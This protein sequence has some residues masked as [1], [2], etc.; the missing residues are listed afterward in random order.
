MVTQTSLLLLSPYGKPVVPKLRG[1]ITPKLVVTSVQSDVKVLLSSPSVFPSLKL[2]VGGTTLTAGFTVRHEVQ[3]SPTGL[4][5]VLV[6]TET[7]V[8]PPVLLLMWTSPPPRIS[9]WPVR[10]TIGLALVIVKRPPGKLVDG[11]LTVR[12]RGHT[13]ES[14]TGPVG[15]EP[16]VSIR[17]SSPT[18][19]TVVVCS[20]LEDVTTP[21]GY[22]GGE[23]QVTLTPSSSHKTPNE[24]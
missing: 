21:L 19:M 24:V 16:P 3:G 20:C 17:P 15:S 22:P 13:V 7:R 1:L 14:L 23:T 9:G 10:T 11:A 2:K 6:I 8:G 18:L 4:L 5:F 12:V